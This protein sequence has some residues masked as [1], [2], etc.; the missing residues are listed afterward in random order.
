MCQQY[1]LAETQTNHTPSCVS[2]S[3]ACRQRKWLF[4]S[5]RHHDDTSGI[6]GLVL[7]PTSNTRNI[8]KMKKS[9]GGTNFFLLAKGES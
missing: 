6:P 2:R 1:V 7:G 8:F 3:I 5:A 9:S 4:I